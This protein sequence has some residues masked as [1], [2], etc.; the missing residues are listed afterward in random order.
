MTALKIL[1]QVHG[2]DVEIFLED[3]ELDADV[4]AIVKGFQEKGLTP[5]PR[6]TKDSTPFEPFIGIV[7]K[8]EETTSK[9]GD[10]QMFIA[11]VRPIVGEG[12]PQKELVAVKYMPPRNTWRVND[13]V[14]VTKNQKGWLE[15]NEDS[16]ATPPF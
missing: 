11:H 14:K 9:A 6:F 4:S 13:R 16:D 5:R 8:T 10:K 12:Q 7:E 2:F 3:L 1:A 15:I